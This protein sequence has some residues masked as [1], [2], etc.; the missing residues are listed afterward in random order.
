MPKQPTF[1]TLY[2]E[3]R[4]IDIWELKRW[5]YIQEGND[6][7]GT[8]RWSRRGHCTGSI[9]FEVWMSQGAPHMLLDYRFGGEARTYRVELESL[10]SNLGKG[11]IW[12]FLCPFTGKR[13]RKL[14][15]VGGWFGHREAFT[16]CMYESQTTGRRWR[17]IEKAY[18]PIFKL[19]RL[20][21]EMFKKHRKTCY[22]GKPTRGQKRFLAAIQ[23][24]KRTRI[25]S[26]SE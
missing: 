20:Y 15:S 4:Q 5:G 22:R 23:K 6:V 2:D 7:G 10:P 9:G 19:E 3:A 1:P 24:A 12:Y 21:E 11:E 25:I 17:E 16:G 18:G 14:Y 26:L 13:C 8:L